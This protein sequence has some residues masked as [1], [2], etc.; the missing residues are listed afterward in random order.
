MSGKSVREHAGW[1]SQITAAISLIIVVYVRSKFIFES[2]NDA[3]LLFIAMVAAVLTLILG[4]AAL[5]RWQAFV[6]L[7]IFCFV[8]YCF[9][10]VS[11]YAL[12]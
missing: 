12:P 5:P 8:A 7:A 4:I 6:A 1:L 9:L 10:F 2:G 3:S 11:M